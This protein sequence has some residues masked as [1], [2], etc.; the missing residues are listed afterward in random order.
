MAHRKKK[1][2]DRYD[3]YKLKAT[4]SGLFF[5]LIPHIMRS[6]LDSMCFFNEKI[7]L[8]P[9]E[10]LMKELRNQGHRDIKTYHIIMAAIVRSISQRPRVNRFVCGRNIY[11]RDHINLS[12]AIKR[13]MSDDGEETTIKPMFD[14][15]DDLFDVARKITET[16]NASAEEDGEIDKFVSMLIKMPNFI[17]RFIVFLA[18]NLDKV[19]L[20]PK[21]IHEISPFHSS[22]FVTDVGSIGIRPIYHHLM[23]SARP[24]CSFPSARRKRS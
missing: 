7:D 21:F 2:S 13:D 8:Q 18:R 9:I 1:L 20:M 14:P 17:R 11:A 3:G 10:A 19:G 16:Y 12:L 22:A 6:R 5:C 4:K 15:Y 23:N 24:P